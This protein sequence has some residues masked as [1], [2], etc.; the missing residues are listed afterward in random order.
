MS[1]ALLET[2]LLNFAVFSFA[3]WICLSKASFLAVKLDLSSSALTVVA[4]TPETPTPANVATVIKPVTNCF[5]FI[6]I[7]TPAFV[8][9]TTD[10]L[11]LD[12]YSLVTACLLSEY[13]LQHIVMVKYKEVH[14]NF[15]FRLFSRRKGESKVPKKACDKRLF[16]HRP[17][18]PVV[19]FIN[20]YCLIVNWLYQSCDLKGYFAA[21]IST[22]KYRFLPRRTM[23]YWPSK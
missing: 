16:Y 11:T 8:L 6:F 22:K 23:T 19:I 18:S 3:V 7:V 13:F 1:N 4:A 15:L 5:N 14:K 12:C 21:L 20:C 2:S 9:F 10:T 17:K